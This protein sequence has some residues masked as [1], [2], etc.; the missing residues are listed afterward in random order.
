MQIIFFMSSCDL[1]AS[2]GASFGFPS[3]GSTECLAQAILISFFWRSCW[4]WTTMLIHQLFR[5]VVKCDEGFSNLTMHLVC[6]G[7]SFILTILPFS[8]K[9]YFGIAETLSGRSFCGFSSS[10]LASRVWF[11]VSSGGVLIVCSVLMIYFLVRIISHVRSKFSTSNMVLTAIDSLKYYPLALFIAY[12]PILISF[13]TMLTKT[14]S[15]LLCLAPLNGTFIAVIFFV[16]CRDL[17]HRWLCLLGFV[18]KSTR[19][20]TDFAHLQEYLDDINSASLQ[21]NS[22]SGSGSGGSVSSN[23]LNSSG[24]GNR[25]SLGGGVGGGTL[26]E[27]LLCDPQPHP[28]MQHQNQD[29]EHLLGDDAV[30]ER[31]SFLMRSNSC[32]SGA[33]SGL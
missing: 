30:E 32:S 9:T 12:G 10:T 31:N 6:W 5:I 11:Y 13:D 16:K 23:T 8:T 2:I 18:P 25:S 7:T 29:L 24:T 4:F 22:G 28:Q 17:R 21:S 27:R 33:H 14:Y 1:I 19:K 26:V 15:M 20:N 3:R